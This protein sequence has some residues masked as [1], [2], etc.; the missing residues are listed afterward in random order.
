MYSTPCSSCGGPRGVPDHFDPAAICVP[1]AA[2]IATDKRFEDLKVNQDKVVQLWTEGFK[3]REIA[4][5]IKTTPNSVGVMIARMRNQGRDIPY[6]Y[7]ANAR[8][9]Q[10]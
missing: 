8:K 7:A 10:R 9:F 5:I 3:L 4:D 6:H 1:C 2:R